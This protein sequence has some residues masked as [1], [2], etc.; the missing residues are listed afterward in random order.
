MC[1]GVVPLEAESE[2]H[3]VSVV[4]VQSKGEPV[5]P[6]KESVCGSGGWPTVPVNRICDWE[7]VSVARPDDGTNSMDSMATWVSDGPFMLSRRRLM[8]PRQ[9][10]LSERFSV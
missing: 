3:E 2:S 6:D 9:P 10:T 4:A 5:K 7:A 1:A 8:I